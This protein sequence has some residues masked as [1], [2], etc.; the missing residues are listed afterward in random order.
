[1]RRTGTCG[2]RRGTSH[3]HHRA[4]CPPARSAPR[5]R[6][7]T[8]VFLS[9]S[10]LILTA[11]LAL[12]QQAEDK[13]PELAEQKRGQLVAIAEAVAVVAGEQRIAS[14]RDWAALVVAIGQAESG[15]SL[16]IHAGRC[17]KWECDRGR[18]RGPW[19]LHR[20]AEAVSTWEQM[21]GL[22]NIAVQVRVASARLRRGYYTCR[23]SADWL[24]ATING[25][26]GISCSRVWPGLERRV[27]VWRAVVRTMDRATRRDGS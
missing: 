11:L 27:A 21:H 18:A 23:G 3:D 13:A 20:Y 1:M 6:T 24:V 10:D 8:G 12:P 9:L 7:P 14:T 5:R 2:A 25:Y 16:R 17:H 26:A 15:F 19:Q 4:R 22:D